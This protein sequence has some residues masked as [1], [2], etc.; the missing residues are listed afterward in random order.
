MAENY[1]NKLTSFDSS[2]KYPGVEDTVVSSKVN[3]LEIRN[4]SF[5][6]TIGDLQI[7][8]YN[9]FEDYREVLDNLCI[10]IDLPESLYYKPEHTAYY[11]YGTVD[12]WYLLLFLND[13]GSFLD[14][15]KPKIKIIPLDKIVVINNIIEKNKERLIYN[16]NNP[17]E[18]EDIPFKRI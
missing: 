17:Q 10:E 13:I 3:K 11:I 9:I 2:I 16:T 15:T 1:Q 14:F 5:G 6:Y 18:L 7:T 4:T 8:Q 12:L